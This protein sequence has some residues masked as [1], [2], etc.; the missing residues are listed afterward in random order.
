M[1]QNDFR[2]HFGLG[3]AARI[4]RIEVRWPNGH[5]EDWENLPVDSFQT[6]KEGSGHDLGR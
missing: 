6:L 1:S 4:E 3:V 2:V 5:E